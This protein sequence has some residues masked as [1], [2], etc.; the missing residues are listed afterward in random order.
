MAFY[1]GDNDFIRLATGEI[2]QSPFIKKPFKLKELRFNLRPLVEQLLEILFIILG[3]NCIQD[4]FDGGRPEAGFLEK[5]TQ[6][7]N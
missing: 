7:Y 5:T 6:P 3:Q 1:S 2:R 4:N